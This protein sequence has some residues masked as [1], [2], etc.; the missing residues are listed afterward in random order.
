LRW[1]IPESVESV[2]ID[3]GAAVIRTSS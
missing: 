1:R 2:T 3:P